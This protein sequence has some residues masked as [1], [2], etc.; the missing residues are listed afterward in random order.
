MKVQKVKK[1]DDRNGKKGP[2]LTVATCKECLFS[3][4][5]PCPAIN[6]IKYKVYYTCYS[7]L[8]LNGI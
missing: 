3:P 5:F 4:P 7:E 2:P 6:M 8:Q 1:K